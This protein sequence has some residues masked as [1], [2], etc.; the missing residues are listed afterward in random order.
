M[1]FAA[2]PPELNSAQIYAG[3]GTGPLLSAAASWDGLAAEWSAGARSFS[4]TG[5]LT[6]PLSQMS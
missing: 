3:A 6:H 5:V 4:A 1:S 2:L